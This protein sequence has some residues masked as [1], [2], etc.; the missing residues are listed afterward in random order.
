AEAREG[1][2][3]RPEKEVQG[4]DGRAEEDRREKRAHPAPRLRPR[5]AP[6]GSAQEFDPEEKPAGERHPREGRGVGVHPA[7][8]KERSRGG[9][10]EKPAEKKEEG[11]PPAHRHPPPGPCIGRRRTCQCAEAAARPPSPV[12]CTPVRAEAT[13]MESGWSSIRG[14]APRSEAWAKKK[15]AARGDCGP[16]ER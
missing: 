7:G 16:K 4:E 15:A 11:T 2:G 3:R 8:Q 1:E 14:A 5:S 9:S 10:E 6:R 13:R 12:Q